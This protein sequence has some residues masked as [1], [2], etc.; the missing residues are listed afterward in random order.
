VTYRGPD[1]ARLHGQMSAIMTHASETA[2]WRQY[3]SASSGTGSAIWAGAGI[4]QHYRQQVISG[5]FVP[6]AQR[7]T[8]L[9]AGQ[10]IAG[11]MAFSTFQRLGVQDEV[12]W[13]GVTYRVEGDI[14]PVHLGGRVWYQTMLRR[15]DATG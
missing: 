5:L 2:I 1:P 9:A 6:A 12:Q 8:Q 7:E 11:D 15:G 3:I 14:L 4:T 10:I 13:R